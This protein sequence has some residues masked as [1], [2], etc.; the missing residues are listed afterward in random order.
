MQGPKTKLNK[1]KIST[2]NFK[3]MATMAIRFSFASNVHD[4]FLLNKMGINHE[5]KNKVKVSNLKMV[6]H[7]EMTLK[8]EFRTKVKTNLKL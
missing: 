6:K 1:G 7:V 2:V 5:R 8:E 3:N 4:A